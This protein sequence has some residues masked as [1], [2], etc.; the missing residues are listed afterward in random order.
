MSRVSKV[1]TV[2]AALWIPILLAGQSSPPTDANVVKTKAGPVRA[3]RLVSLSEPWGMSLLPDGRLLITEKPGRLRSYSDGKLSEPIGGVPPVAYRNQGGLLD[4]T[5][6]PDFARNNFI[7]LSYVE[8]AEQQPSDARDPGDSRLG[9]FQD[10]DDNL[11]KGSAV[12][13]ARLD[14][15]TLRDLTVIWRQVPKTIGRGHFGGRLV[16]APD[17]KLFIT[18][19]DRQRFEPAQ[20]LMTNL[21][22]V[23]RINSDGTIPVSYTHLTLPTNR[24]V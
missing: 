23:V 16:F 20:D 12:A 4:V 5:I 18:S 3:E 22:K 9:Q 2:V 14:G 7:Y 24:E 15:N 11:L 19:G 21:G 1:A 6:D 17:G 10:L 8:A 13:R